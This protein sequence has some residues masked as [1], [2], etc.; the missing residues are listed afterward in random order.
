MMKGNDIPDIPGY[1]SVKEAAQI[2]DVSV[3]RMYE[4]VR[5]RRLPL[6][7]AGK[8][9]MIPMESLKDFKPQPTGRMRIR[10]PEWR[11]YRGGGNVLATEIRA[12][13]RPGLQE[14]FIAKLKRIQEENRHTFPGTIARYVLQD[15][16]SGAFVS[17][18]LIWKDTEMPDKA[19]RDRDIEEFK[20]ELAD[21]LDWET[22]QI[23]LKEGLIYT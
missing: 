17:I 14:N 4:Y 18:W 13:I 2:L 23:S 8:T 15:D 10:P 7:K 3:S 22:A 19:I 5:E 9:Y 12:H 16:S 21:V 1:V 6:H 11:V 20:A